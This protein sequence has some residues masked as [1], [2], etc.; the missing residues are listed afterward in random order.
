[1][2]EEKTKG[3]NSGV[4]LEF[5][6]GDPPQKVWRAI[7]IPE[8]RERWLPMEA[9]ADPDAVTVTPGREVRYKL[10]DDTP[11]FLESTVTLTITPNET[12]GTSLRIVHELTDVRVDR[13][14]NAAANCNRPPLML[15][16]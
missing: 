5:D 16:A 6:L 9:L 12:G 14:A 1:V 13:M 3:Q 15:A 7:S 4:K 10:R 8:F 2:N 11:P